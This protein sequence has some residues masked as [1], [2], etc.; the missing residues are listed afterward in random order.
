VEGESLSDW[1]CWVFRLC[2]E[3]W[4]FG[5]FLLGVL[6]RSRFLSKRTEDL[7][8]GDHLLECEMGY[9]GTP[10]GC[11]FGNPCVYSIQ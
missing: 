9:G 5:G 2:V 6:E 1:R 3:E 4:L 10:G 8:C 11:Y 7:D